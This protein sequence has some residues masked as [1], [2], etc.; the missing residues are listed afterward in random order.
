MILSSAS[1]YVAAPRP[2]K[3]YHRL[4]RSSSAAAVVA[5]A[6]RQRRWRR[7]AP[8]SDESDVE[9]ERELDINPA[10]FD[11]EQPLS[12]SVVEAAPQGG[13][14]SSLRGAD[15]LQALQRKAAAE[16]P[17]GGARKGAKARRPGAKARE[18]SGEV[19]DYS[20]VRPLEVK[21][22]WAFRLE[23]LDRLVQELQASPRIGQD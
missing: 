20:N 14:D 16:T 7:P 12:W 4:H 17:K 11:S 21:S 18:G 3:S 6:K 19:W 2:Q 22:D 10:P 5:F 13:G 1:A 23:E 15:I 8:E 9:G